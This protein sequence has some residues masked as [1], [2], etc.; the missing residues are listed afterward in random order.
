[1]AVKTW[2][3]VWLHY[4]PL[5]ILENMSK[6]TDKEAVDVLTKSVAKFNNVADVFVKT[7]VIYPV[8]IEYTKDSPETEIR[9]FIRAGE[10]C[11]QRQ[12][13]MAKELEKEYSELNKAYRDSLKARKIPVVAKEYPLRATPMI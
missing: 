9:T 13:E 2:A 10:Y 11:S 4:Q 1:M 6:I 5:P 8:T 7:T 3:V 12:M